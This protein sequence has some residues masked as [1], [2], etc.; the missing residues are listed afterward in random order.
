MRLRGVALRVCRRNRA[1]RDCLPARSEVLPNPSG[2]PSGERRRSQGIQS[3]DEA[4]KVL[5]TQL[6]H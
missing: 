3:L 2:V 1:V 5:A 4:C 6:T